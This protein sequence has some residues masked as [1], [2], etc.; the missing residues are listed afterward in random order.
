MPAGL[1]KV[2]RMGKINI[3]VAITFSLFAIVVLFLSAGLPVSEAAPLTMGTPL[4]PRMLSYGILFL[5]AVLI[6]TN[7]HEART[8][9]KEDRTKLFEPG[10][11]KIVGTGLGIMV[12]GAVVMIYF[13][14]IPAMILM[15]LAYLLFFKV[16]SKAVLIVEPVITTVLIYVVFNYLLTV[17]LP[18]GILFY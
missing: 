16:R 17:P 1:L 9:K 11:L 2:I 4:F 18:T 15:N 13:G 5:S 14:F 10:Q 12:I 6:A 8:E 7:W 3:I